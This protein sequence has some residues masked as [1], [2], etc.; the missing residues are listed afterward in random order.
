MP[1][2]SVIIPT[3]NRANMLRIALDSVVKQAFCDFELLVIDDG[4]RDNTKEVVLGFKDKRIIYLRRRHSGVVAA[5]NFA[6]SKA[7]G[8][9]IAYLDDDDIYYP[10]HLKKLS[11]FLD[12]HPD[13]GLVYGQVHFKFGKRIF[14][15]Y[16]FDYDKRRLE[17]DDI[18]P[19]NSLMHR[20]ACLSRVGPFHKLAVSSDWEMWLRISDKYRI[21]HINDIVGR[22][23]CHGNNLSG[24]I[25]KYPKVY[26]H[27]INKRMDVNK[28][29]SGKFC[30]FPG[31]YLALLY[32]LVY[33]FKTKDNECI[34]FAKDIINKDKGSPEAR[35]G[36][37]ACY[38]SYR[39][40][41]LA[42][43]IV[44]GYL[45]G[46]TSINDKY[47][48]NLWRLVGYVYK[49]RMRGSPSDLISSFISRF[50]AAY[51]KE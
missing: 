24:D 12:L 48:F 39:R 15:P 41:E 34:R 6:L 19:I 49:R 22:V 8:R 37:C 11:A 9:Y 16:P 51:A 17:V 45:A 1:K 33:K 29:N 43:R 40:Y 3:R 50:L 4:S 30:L 2:I 35:L 23:L 38:L 36:L 10:G 46:N 7:R 26:M 44:K 31:Y 25:G 42:T 21:A 18:I 32:R 28:K 13:I 5:R 47:A 20:K 27:I 14:L